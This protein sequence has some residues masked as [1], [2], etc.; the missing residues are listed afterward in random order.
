MNRWSLGGGGGM[1]APNHNFVLIALMIMK[2]GTGIKI[3]VFYTIV[4]K[5]FLTSLLLRKYDVIA[6]ILVDR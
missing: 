6:C 3:D 2:F 1:S 4:A 5:T